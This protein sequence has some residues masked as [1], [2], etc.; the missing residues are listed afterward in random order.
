MIFF[1]WIFIFYFIPLPNKNIVTS[2]K[3]QM[4]KKLI[5]LSMLMGGIAMFMSCN[6]EKEEFDF[7]KKVYVGSENPYNYVGEQ[8]NLYLDSIAISLGNKSWF[9]IQDLYD[10]N[11]SKSIID[12]STV[13]IDEYVD[14]LEKKQSLAYDYLFENSS[15]FD[16]YGVVVS[17]FMREYKNLML[18]ILH[19][20]EDVAPSEFSERINVIEKHVLESEYIEKKEYE[21]D[22]KVVLSSLAVAKY[23]YAYWY[24][25]YSNEK[26][27]WNKIVH[28]R[29]DNL[30]E[31]QKEGV[32]EKE[33]KGFLSKVVSGVVKGVKCVAAAVATVPV[34]L[35]GAASAMKPTV[36]EQGRVKFEGS[37][38]GMVDK[39]K[40]ASA[41]VWDRT[42]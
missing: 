31:K 13:T 11:V 26:H 23:S 39:A 34:D 14:E 19:S 24:A 3:T 20:D 4:K 2:K 41:S 25:A 1:V 5:V 12:K 32:K 18:S 28:Y 21:T 22:I 8:H 15:L 42:L 40:D 7:E 10:Y 30:Y 27:P 35:V 16:D 37:I 38:S 9:E 6:Q 36:D 17:S 29:L 33:K